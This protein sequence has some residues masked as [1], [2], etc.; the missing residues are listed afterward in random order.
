MNRD[1]PFAARIAFRLPQSLYDKLEMWAEEEDR[2]LANLVYTLVKQA[3]TERERTLQAF[4]VKQE[5]NG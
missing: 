4:E 2:P 3:V 5:I 1:T